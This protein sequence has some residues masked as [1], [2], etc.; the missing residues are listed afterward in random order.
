MDFDI[1][2]EQKVYIRNLNHFIKTEI[3]DS[4]MSFQK[5]WNAC[6]EYG[7]FGIPYSEKYGGL[8]ESYL[9]A[10]MMMQELGYT[11]DDNGFIF[12]ITNHV[13]A[14]LN[15]LH[16]YGTERIREKYLKSMICGQRIGALA[17]TEADSGSNFLSLNT[18]AVSTDDGYILNGSKAFIS[19]GPI[20][21]VFIIS[22]R[23]GTPGALNS[24][25]CFV[26]EKKFPG[27]IIAKNTPKMGL[28]NCPMSDIILKNV[29]VPKENILGKIGNGIKI[30]N[31]IMEWERCFEFAVQ[32]GTMKRIMENCIEYSHIKKIDQYQAVTHKI[33]QMKVYIELSE[34]LL[35][36]VAWMKDEKRSAFLETSIFKYFV[37]EKYVQT[38]LDMLQIFGA[39]GYAVES[40]IEREV[41]DAL[42][43]KIYAGASEIQLN[44]IFR[45][46]KNA[47]VQ[48]KKSKS[49]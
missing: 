20:A 7:L 18:L 35:Y 15:S 42:S 8:N 16:S 47:M 27:F 39:Y 1:T 28:H 46:I 19:N 36:K 23:T 41:R 17:L 10:A 21:D 6:G 33:A 29:F 4:D 2:E 25:S 24:I 44:T 22:A 48:H 3:N 37:S 40:G 38:C 11:C 32:I 13:W 45:L 12:S 14:C 31:G 5:K 30:L 43:S 49:I 26:C 34:L 9:T